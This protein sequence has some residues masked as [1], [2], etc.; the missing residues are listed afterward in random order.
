ML[1]LIRRDLTLYF[2]N[3]SGVFF[4]LMGAMISFVLYL[5][6]LKHSMLSA[7]KMVPDTTKLLDPWLIGGTLTI[8]A[9]TTTLYALQIMVKDRETGIL[10]DLTMT[11]VSSSVISFAYVFSAMIIG[12][13]MQIVMLIIMETYFSWQDHLVFSW[14][15]GWKLFILIVLSS[16]TFSLFNGVIVSF[17]KKVSTMSMINS[18]FGTAAGFLACVYIPIGLLPD[19]AQKVVKKT[20]FVYDASAFRRVLMSYQL[21]HSFRNVSTKT[22]TTFK[23]TMGVGVKLPYMNTQIND[24]FVLLI[25]AVISLLSLFLIRK[26]FQNKQIAKV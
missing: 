3:Y 16:L 19:F 21:N 7:W 18:I 22:L 14:S 25:V 23:K 10:A 5:I 6:F 13:V 4:S 20:P 11:S 24:Y 8:T 1:S 9:L 2:R 12:I 15:E 17:I 26:V